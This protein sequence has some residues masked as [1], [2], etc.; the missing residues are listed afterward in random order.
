VTA[1]DKRVEINL[2]RILFATDFSFCSARAHPYV[3]S[4]ARHYASTVRLI[5][6][7]SIAAALKGPGARICARNLREDGEDRL[8]ALSAEF[9]S[10]DI[11]VE[12]SLCE[13]LD[14]ASEIRQAAAEMSADLIVIG[15]SGSHGLERLAF[16][17]TAEALIHRADCPVLTVGPNVQPPGTG[18]IFQNIVYATDFTPAAANAAIAAFSVAKEYGAHIYL[19]H[20]D[21]PPDKHRPI[22]TKERNEMF[23]AAVAKLIPEI[24][25]DWCEPECVLEHGYAADGIRLLAY[26]VNADLLVL[27]ARRASHW[28]AT[29]K[30]GIAFQVIRAVSCPVLTIRG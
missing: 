13:G 18:R 4:L 6:V 7:V 2:E 16:G 29:I 14:T 25:R 9:A 19:C 12:I 1:L 10:S 5:H 28:F 30:A 8:N 3:L 20:V 15:T 11:K 26:R 24:A 17:S 23:N 22:G 27:G 21:P